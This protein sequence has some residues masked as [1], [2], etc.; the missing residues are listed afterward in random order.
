M[1]L[2]IDF[3][4]LLYFSFILLQY[5]NLCHFNLLLYFDSVYRSM[6]FYCIKFDWFVINCILFPYRSS[7]RHALAPQLCLLTVPLFVAPFL[8][9]VFIVSYFCILLLSSFILYHNFI[10]F[11]FCISMWFYWNWNLCLLL[12]FYILCLYLLVLW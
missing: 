4:W 6:V 9:L 11:H 12:Y 10:V 2:Y 3:T 8:Y 5:F 7:P 1:L